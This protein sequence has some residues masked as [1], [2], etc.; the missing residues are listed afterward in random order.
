VEASGVMN[1]HILH[2][3]L[4]HEGLRMYFS[5]PYGLELLLVLHSAEAAGAD[6]GI[7]DTFDTIRFNKPRRAAFSSFIQQLELNG[8][9]LKRPSEFKASK[10]VLRL[11]DGVSIALKGFLGTNSFS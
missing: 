9:V 6:N 7:D 3:A 1:L 8:H 11:S 10:S 5:K 2:T 4:S